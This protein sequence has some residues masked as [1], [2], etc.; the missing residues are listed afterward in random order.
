MGMVFLVTIDGY[1]WVSF[2]QRAYE[3]HIVGGSRPAELDIGKQETRRNGMA[4]FILSNN[5]EATV[6]GSSPNI[7]KLYRIAVDH[8][9]VIPQLHPFAF[10]Q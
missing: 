10:G 2:F 3:P 7:E 6:V 1:D 8:A 9:M 4:A 5:L